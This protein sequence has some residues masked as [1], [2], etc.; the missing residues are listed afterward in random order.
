MKREELKNKKYLLFDLDGTLTDS[1]EGILRCFR[2]AFETLGIE[3]PDEGR[4]KSF[5]GPPLSASFRSVIGEDE[6]KVAEAVRIYRE[7]YSTIGLFENRPYDGTDILLR[8]LRDS[9]YTLAVAT[10]K[11]EVFSRR[12]LDRFGL[13]EY[14]E[15]ITGCG[16]DGTLDTK[17]EVIEETLRRLGAADKAEC[18]MIGD[19]KQDILGAHEAGLE[20]IGVYWGFAEDGELEASGADAI[21]NTA[22]ELKEM[23]I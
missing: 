20:C 11:P 1:Q 4:M 8:K 23:F 13:S 22:E 5:L 6:V 18:I 3:V 21:A 7:R 12:I 17:A 9:G 14:F 2:H 16:L 10:S 15:V 19:R